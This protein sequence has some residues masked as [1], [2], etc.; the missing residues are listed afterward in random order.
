MVGVFIILKN[1]MTSNNKDTDAKN[2][3][4]VYSSPSNIKNPHLFTKKSLLYLIETWNKNKDDQIIYKKT[5]STAKL[6]SLLNDKI[7]PIC[8]DKQYWCWTGALKKLTNDVNTRE[9][10][11]VIENTEMRPEMPIKWTKNPIEWLDNYDIEDVMIQYNNDKKYKYAFLGVFPI[12]FTEED[13]FGRCL[14]STI[15]TIDIKKYIN[16][17]IKYIGLITNLD[18]HDQGG[19]HWTSTFIIIDP[20]NKCYGAHY[21]DSNAVN[22]P[23][24]IKKFINTVK[25]KLSEIYPKTKFNVTFNTKRHQMKNTECGMFSL[26]YQIRWL[27]AIIKYKELNLTSP[28][29]DSNFHNYIVND[30]NIT[31]N[32][33]EKTRSYLFRP[34]L[35]VYLKDKKATI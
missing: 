14:Y 32:N 28:Y 35:K 31:D 24:Y 20:K 26:S 30:E 11:K 7:K 29:D 34:N 13:K 22:I 5:F 25:S 15:C 19:S 4:K 23:S 33:M 8:D 12:D 2:I 10:I 17:K 27:N 6:S 1:I 21:Y 9:I 18:K 16:K 3:N